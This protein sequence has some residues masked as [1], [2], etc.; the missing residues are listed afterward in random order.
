[1]TTESMVKDNPILKKFFLED[2]NDRRDIANPNPRKTWEAV[3]ADDL[4]RRKKVQLLLDKGTIKTAEDYY[5]AA[6]I[7]QHG[8]KSDEYR[9]AKDLAEKSVNM[10]NEEA[11]WLYAA[12]TDRLLC[13]L[14]KK[15]K[16]G[17]QYQWVV[18]KES[19]KY[20]DAMLLQPYDKRTTDLLRAKYNVPPLHILQ[21]N[22]RKKKRF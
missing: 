22:E 19:E 1:M 13:A 10:G 8:T 21:K 3:T 14:G 16:F 12:T 20:Y 9:L 18:L 7:F 17:T 5:R 4:K 15:Q 2:Q 11:R 6:M